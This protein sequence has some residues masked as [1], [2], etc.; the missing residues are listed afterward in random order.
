MMLWPLSKRTRIAL[1]TINAQSLDVRYAKPYS[2]ED[3]VERSSS[4]GLD[5]ARS[6]PNRA[7]T[8][9]RRPTTGLQRDYQKTS[10]PRVDQVASLSCYFTKGRQLF[11]GTR[12]TICESAPEMIRRRSRV[13]GRTCDIGEL[14]LFTRRGQDGDPGGSRTPNPQIRSLMLYPVELRGQHFG[15]FVGNVQIW[16]ARRDS[17]SRPNGS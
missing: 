1:S 12:R 14:R 2:A 6:D 7:P 13:P 4:I 15:M 16:W 11:P 3:R 5:M 17:N 10:R 8:V 9:T